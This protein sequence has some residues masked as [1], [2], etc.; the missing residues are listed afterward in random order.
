MGRKRFNTVAMLL[1]LGQRVGVTA[2]KE[3]VYSF[4]FPQRGKCPQCC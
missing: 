4:I 1:L 3:S 2:R